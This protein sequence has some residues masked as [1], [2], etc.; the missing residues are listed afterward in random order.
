MTPTRL[1]VIHNW[2]DARIRP[3]PRRAGERFTIAY[4]GNLGRAHDVNAIIALVER[5]DSIPDLT[6]L[7]IGGGAGCDRLKQVTDQRALGNVMFEPAVACSRLSESLARADLH[8]VSLE[9][10]CEGLMMPSKLYGIMAAGRPTLFLGSPEGAV[11]R[12]LRAHDAGIALDS[13]RP[14]A[15]LPT[16]RS[17]KEDPVRLAAMARNARLAFERH[18][19]ADRSLKAWKDILTGAPASPEID[20]E[21][22]AV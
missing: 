7:F 20:N 22:L 17:L 5:T 3:L 21:R 18:Y 4:S 9:P 10:T 15:Y 2:P 12:I 11:A 6:W 16:V 13:T 8:L 19:S 14:D 1:Q